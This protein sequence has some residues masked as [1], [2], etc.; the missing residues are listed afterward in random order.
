[1]LANAHKIHIPTV[2][3]MDTGIFYSDN[4][5]DSSLKL[6]G[7]FCSYSD[8]LLRKKIIRTIIRME[9]TT[10]EYHPP[11]KYLECHNVLYLQAFK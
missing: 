6:F 5:K 11:D 4:E 7:V 10:T 8:L 3:R 9:Q 2:H 1:M